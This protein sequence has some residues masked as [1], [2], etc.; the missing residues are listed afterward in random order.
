MV[1]KIVS[2]EEYSECF[3]KGIKGKTQGL[4]GRVLRGKSLQDFETLSEDPSRRIVFAVDDS[5]LESYL[6]HSTSEILRIV[7]YTDSY[8]RHLFDEGFHFRLAIFRA[9]P[10]ILPATWE[11]V[12]DLVGQIY[13]AQVKSILSG[14]VPE[15][16]SLSFKKIEGFAPSPFDLVHNA[17]PSHPEYINEN[18]LLQGSAELWQ[19]RAFLYHK[20]RLTELFTGTGFTSRSSTSSGVPEYLLVNCLVQQLPEVQVIDLM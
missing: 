6:C 8:I 13:G 18:Q 3:K 4:Y 12:V 5:C 16:K 20:L 7:G 1:R 9:F 15:F 17:G 11:N 10:G 14:Y 2:P 19:V